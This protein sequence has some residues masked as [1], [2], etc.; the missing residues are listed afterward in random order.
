MIVSGA[1]IAQK[2]YNNNNDNIYLTSK[3]YNSGVIK[4]Q[5]NKQK[6]C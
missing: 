6:N 3:I 2:V 1:D 5:K 4:K